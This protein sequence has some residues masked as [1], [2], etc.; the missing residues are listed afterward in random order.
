MRQL[1]MEIS[2]ADNRPPL[3]MGKDRVIFLINHKNDRAAVIISRSYSR[4]FIEFPLQ[5]IRSKVL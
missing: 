2:I 5:K 1:L 3:A 4:A